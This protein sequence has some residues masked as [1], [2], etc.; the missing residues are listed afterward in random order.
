MDKCKYYSCSNGLV[1]GGH[2]NI[3][4]ILIRPVTL[5]TIQIFGRNTAIH[6]FNM[7]LLQMEANLDK[8][9]E[10]G[11]GTCQQHLTYNANEPFM[12]T[13]HNLALLTD[14]CSS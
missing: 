8:V 10:G 12:P 13:W 6:H 3:G 11:A 14:T 5:Y 9:G 2:I 4:E 7:D 1:T